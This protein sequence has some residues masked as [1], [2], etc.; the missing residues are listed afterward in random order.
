MKLNE[1]YAKY[2]EII[3]YLVFGVLTTAVSWVTYFAVMYG[4]RAVFEIPSGDVKSGA[5]LAVYTASQIISWVAAVLFAFYTN[6]K[7]VFEDSD[8]SVPVIGQLAVFA[9]GRLLTL[10][11]DFVIT[12]VGTLLLTAIL[13]A[14]MFGLNP[15]EIAA[16]LV[17]AL[18]VIA[19]NYVFSKLFVFRGKKGRQN[20]GENTENE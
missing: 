2:K 13:P 19:G 14:E 18:V 17:A 1:I 4:M 20:S 15:S 8:S 11:L 7:W 12:Y 10:G 9:S 3:L 5:Y 16:K 6:R